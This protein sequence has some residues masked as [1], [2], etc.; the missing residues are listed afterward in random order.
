MPH[1]GTFYI[2]PLFS[3]TSRVL[4]TST[5]CLLPLFPPSV[6][7]PFLQ[8]F[9]LSYVLHPS[10]SVRCLDLFPLNPFCYCISLLPQIQGWCI[11]TPCLSQLLPIPVIGRS[12]VEIS[13]HLLFL[14]LSASRTG[15]GNS[16]PNPVNS[17][18]GCGSLTLS[19]AA[20]PQKA[21]RSVSNRSCG[22][23]ESKGPCRD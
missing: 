18:T 17:T 19:S 14:S 23:L 21:G 1:T 16:L 12:E 5:C 13:S 9:L 20:K 4:T 15:G 22:I 6:L 8:P 10:P 7:G 2:L 3:Q 11:P